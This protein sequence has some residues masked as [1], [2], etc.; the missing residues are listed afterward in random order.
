M[1]A[2]NPSATSSRETVCREL[3]VLLPDLRGYARFLVRDRAGADDLVQDTLVKALAAL[4][5]F[6]PGSN[7]KAWLFVIL[8]NTFYEQGRRARRERAALHQRFDGEEAEAPRQVSRGD[9]A[10][11]Q[12]LLWTLPPLLREAIIL[13]GAQELSYEEAARICTVPVG[14]MKARVSRARARLAGSMSGTDEPSER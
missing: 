7:L 6:Q 14:T 2:S 11:L 3:T 8:R 9:V 5:Q 13:V 1:H 10:D 4:S 12:R